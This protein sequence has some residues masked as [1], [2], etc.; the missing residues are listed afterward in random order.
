MVVSK[1]SFSEEKLSLFSLSLFGV[2]IILG[3]GIY[4]I[5]GSA[6]AASGPS[7]WISFLSAAIVALL[8]GLSYC[9][10]ATIYPKAGAE[11]TY[12]KNA[13]PDKEWAPFLLGFVLLFAGCATAAT[14]SIGFGN[15][16][17]QFVEISSWVSALGL[18]LLV[19]I[20]NSIGIQNSSKVNIVF[21][22]IE[23]IGL[24]IVIWYGFNHINPVIKPT[25]TLTAGTFSSAALIF[26]VYLGFEDI[27]NLA[28]DT[29]NPEKNIPK[30]IIISLIVTTILYI[31]VAIAVLLLTTPE[32]LSK[33]N[34][35]LSA[36]LLKSAP[37][38]VNTLNTIAL[39]STAN[40]ALI[41]MLAVSKMAFGIAKQGD[42]PKFIS[43]TRGDKKIPLNANLLIFILSGVFL[44]LGNLE[45]LASV[46]SFCALLGF[47]SVN[48]VVI[49]LRF[50][51]PELNR[52][53]KTPLNIGKFP[54]IAGLGFLTV[55]LMLTQFKLKILV[56]SFFVISLGMT[57]YYLKK[58]LLFNS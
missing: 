10:L 2:G 3:A 8:T 50:K 41:T 17:N 25:F 29:Q 51:K 34:V 1:E 32:I 33:S 7:L 46:S 38:W 45:D 14:I 27:V 39:F 23:V 35:P 37:Q 43:Y 24:L 21:T 16:L 58:K 26:F 53:F 13:Y 6:A 11:Y 31:A 5:L 52:P 12:L 18:L 19:S 55:I 48:W 40:T 28:E 22:L 44:A 56:F 54:I 57:Y 47:L 4:A 9:E 15:Y 49:V 20:I 36:A 42:L 30:A